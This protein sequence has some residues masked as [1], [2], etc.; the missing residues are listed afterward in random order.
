MGRRRVHD[1]D[2]ILDAAEEL[3]ATGG[4]AAITVRA[5]AERTGAPSGSLYHLFG[6]RPELLARLWIRAAERFLAVQAAA[7]D[8]ALGATSRPSRAAAVEATVAASTTL[9]DLEQL[10]P[11]TALVLFGRGRDELLTRDLP[12]ALAT[13]VARLE[14]RL[15]ALMRRLAEALWRRG[16]RAA[17]ETIAACVVDIAGAIL[18]NPRPRVIDTRAVVRAAVEGVLRDEPPRP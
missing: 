13:D 11:H 6:S 17:V 18:L 8:A 4:A 14:G 10:A 3:F 16:D 12:V 15:T 7:V 1:P 5:L 2:A 9:S